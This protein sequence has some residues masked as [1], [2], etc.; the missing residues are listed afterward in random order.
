MRGRRSSF[1][2]KE[3]LRRVS[4][5]TDAY[6]LQESNT[7]PISAIAG[8]TRLPA[9]IWYVSRFTI[10]GPKWIYW[11][12]S[13]LQWFDEYK[14][15]G[16]E[17]YI[18]A[19]YE[20]PNRCANY[21]YLPLWYRKSVYHSSY[22]GVSNLHSR[23]VTWIIRKATTHDWCCTYKSLIDRFRDNYLRVNLKASGRWRKGNLSIFRS[24]YNILLDIR[25]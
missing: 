20:G 25:I 14:R 19:I 18:I 17:M 21:S 12:C 8:M 9:I 13:Q 22:P 23:L 10:Q 6:D 24:S 7:F 5:T 11:V 2:C 3:L 1:L 16:S 15:H 4:A